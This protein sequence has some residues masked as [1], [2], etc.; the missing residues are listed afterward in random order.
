MLDTITIRVDTT[1][2]KGSPNTPAPFGRCLGHFIPIDWH[3]G[4]YLHIFI[5]AQMCGS[6]Q[7]LLADIV[8][9]HSRTRTANSMYYLCALYVGLRI[10]TQGGQGGVEYEAVTDRG[11]GIY[12]GV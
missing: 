3:I 9:S 2:F 11:K 6:R 4:P 10:G 7:A 8:F 1:S 12:E 5:A